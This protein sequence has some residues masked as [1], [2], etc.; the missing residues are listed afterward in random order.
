MS[1][2]V[3]QTRFSEEANSEAKICAGNVLGYTLGRKICG[4]G[5]AAGLGRSRRWTVIQSQQKDS[6]DSSRALN[7]GWLFKVVLSCGTMLG[8]YTLTL[9]CHWVDD[10]TFM[11][12]DTPFAG[13]MSVSVLDVQDP[14]STP[15]HPLQGGTHFLGSHFLNLNSDWMNFR[16][17]L[18]CPHL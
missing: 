13:K 9:T 7:L 11:R 17:V 16:L 12:C 4:R 14:G 18:Q 2:R 8:V 15:Q 6:I 3:L 1:E 5:K 10:I